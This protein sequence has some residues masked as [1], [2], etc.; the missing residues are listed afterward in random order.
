MIPIKAIRP[1]RNRTGGNMISIFGIVSVAVALTSV[2]ILALHNRVMSKRAPVDEYFAA[3]EALLRDK[4]EDL[5]QA[6]QPDSRLHSLCGQYIDLDLNE[7]IKALPE[8]DRANFAEI[9]IEEQAIHEAANALNQAIE[10]YNR[11][12]TGSL[13]VVLMAH[14][15]AL[16]AEEPVK[17]KLP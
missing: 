14:I 9:I 6:S 5:Y 12:I 1:I 8:I 3:L 7:I 10:A 15:L 13:P 4:I 16:T 17:V 11:F 2:V